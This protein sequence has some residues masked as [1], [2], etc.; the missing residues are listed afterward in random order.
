MR[1]VVL[2][3]GVALAGLASAGQVLEDA[4][5]SRQP[6]Q[7]IGFTKGPALTPA[8]AALSALDRLAAET[9]ARRVRLPVSLTLDE[10]RLAIVDARLGQPGDTA[11]PRIR[12]D[13]GALGVSLIDRTRDLCPVGRPCALRLVGYWRGRTDGVG[14]LDVRRVDGLAPEAAAW[15]IEFEIEGPEQGPER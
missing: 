8:A 10:R 14:T 1:A 5:T 3:C 12:L 9:R 15:F 6:R 13:D 2:P 4:A 7:E 11:A